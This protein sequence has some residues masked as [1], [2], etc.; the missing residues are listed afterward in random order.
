MTSELYITPKGMLRDS[1]D[2]FITGNGNGLLALTQTEFTDEVPGK[3]YFRKIFTDRIRVLSSVS[4][5]QSKNLSAIFDSTRPDEA[6][7]EL[8]V[9]AAPPLVGGEYLNSELLHR[10]HLDFEQAL[11]ERFTNYERTFTDFIRSLSP[12]W[13][14]VGKVV[15][16]LAENKSANAERFP[17]AFMA[18]F[19]HR[20]EGERPLHLPLAASLKAY[21][22]DSNALSAVLAPIQQ[23]AE[24][25]DLIRNLLESR[26]IFQPAAWT[27]DEAFAFLKDIKLFEEANIVVRIT[28]LW[29]AEPARA[30]VA[31]RL[32][33]A[34]GSKLGAHELLKFSVKVTLNG[35]DLTKDEIDEILQSSGGLVR[36]RGQWIEANPKKIA[37]LL[38]Y[39]QNAEKLANIGGISVSEGLRLLA[40]VGL[41]KE[42][43]DDADEAEYCE[44]KAAGELE[45]TLSGLKNPGA[46]SIPP[47]PE[48]LEK[49]LRPYQVVGLKY[50]WQTSS[51]G[52]GSCLADDMGLG[53][54]LQ[55]LSLLLLWKQAGEL[56]AS[57]AL[58]V[59]PASLLANWKNESA[60]FTPDLR[61]TTLHTSAM[62]KA[63]W[64]AFLADP[65]QHL[66]QYDLALVTYAMLPRIPALSE[67]EFAAVIAD[68]AQ[69][70]KNPSAKQSRAVRSLKGK[71]RIALTGTPV[72]NRLADL[73]SIFDF[74]NP[75]LLGNLRPFL[76]FVKRLDGN[77]TP[78]RKLTQPFILRR[79]KTDKTIISDLPDKTEMKVFCNLTKKQV[80]L[81]AHSVQEMKTALDT[82]DEFQRG[83][84]VLGYLLRF[85]Q[86]CNHPAQFSGNGDFA[87]TDSGKFQRITEL[88]ESIASRQE[89]VLVFTQFREMTE[90]LYNH[91]RK[92]FNKEG[93]ILHGG[94]PVK[95]RPKLVQAF[96][97]D[98]NLPFFVLS[99][100]AAGVG[101]NLTAANHVIHFDRWWNP[102]VEN[103][104][105]DRA[106]RIGQKRNVLIHKFICKG[107]LE[108]KIDELISE[109]QDLFNQVLSSGAEK[110][111]TEM[112]NS[113]LLNLVEL[114]LTTSGV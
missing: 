23:A 109:K 71:R 66:S 87:D 111:L 59:L 101:L 15:F 88:V 80:A 95:E 75:G 60:R 52:F 70:I 84:V 34:V 41:S 45:K 46:I 20:A 10:F 13:K 9:L 31:V 112:S 94:T 53:K 114:N 55:L 96:Q 11:Q 30:K 73:W 58:L 33:S 49:T 64:K 51:L 24:K 63:E 83:G 76:E 28:N 21:S 32:D 3:I 37:E 92:C 93:L 47:L 108:E 39:W 97:E 26:R 2:T 50:L 8:M 16:H 19:I 29:Q 56:A 100:K 106:Y 77:Y 48:S 78:L 1:E 89:K 82:C 72:E 68:E 67:I 79:L 40:G 35:E 85:K 99:L 104:A 38:G 18:S 81:Y 54:T 36:I 107:T 113:E 43:D 61:I 12:A 57:P 17:F 65:A 91:L 103:Q 27:S 62:S 44:F 105:S 74:V 102:A 6:A 69:A 5:P 42:S 98:E 14:N 110:L 25:S 4:E 7:C 90:P 22:G 86:I